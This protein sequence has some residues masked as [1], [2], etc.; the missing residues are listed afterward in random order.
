MVLGLVE[1]SH[2]NFSE[3]TRMVLVEQNSVM[4]LTS[5][6]TSTTGMLS[7]FTN[8]T[9]TGTHVSSLFS[10]LKKSEIGRAHV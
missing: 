8:T 5:S 10:V 4:V 9:V 3:V 6:I 7:V 2:T 1:I